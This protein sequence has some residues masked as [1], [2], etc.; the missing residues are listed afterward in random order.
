MLH[1]LEQCKQTPHLTQALLAPGTPIDMYM[2]PNKDIAWQDAALCAHK[3]LEK[4]GEGDALIE[5]VR[6]ITEAGSTSRQWLS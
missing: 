4:S 5:T 2:L 3:D 6:Q 1:V